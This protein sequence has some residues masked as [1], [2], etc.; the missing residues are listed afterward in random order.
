MGHVFE[1][2]STPLLESGGIFMMDDKTT[3]TTLSSVQRTFRQDKPGAP[4]LASNALQPQPS[5]AT[6]AT[7]NALGK[8]DLAEDQ[9]E[10]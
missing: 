10:Q 8:P 2:G 4:N 1:T 7:G 5:S 9:C 3:S 6:F